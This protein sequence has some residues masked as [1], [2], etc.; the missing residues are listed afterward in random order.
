MVPVAIATL[1]VPGTFD[2]IATTSCRYVDGI[3]RCRTGARHRS[4][5][6]CPLGSARAP[7][8]LAT[9]TVPGTGRDIAGATTPPSAGTS[10]VPEVAW[11]LERR[12]GSSTRH[13][14]CDS[15]MSSRARHVDDIDLRCGPSSAAAMSS[16]VPGTFM[17]SVPR[18][19]RAT[20]D[21]PLSR[22]LSAACP[23]RPHA[24]ATA[25]PEGF[26]LSS[27][28]NIAASA[29]GVG[30]LRRDVLLRGRGAS[31]PRRAPRSAGTCTSGGGRR[32]G[33]RCG[34]PAASTC[35]PAASRTG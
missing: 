22:D 31:P 17:T 15:R 32:T 28:R 5:S 25:R 24:G 20:P 13:D 12:P 27:A 1:Q 14:G 6:R 16:L 4:T 8:R 30:W 34:A 3:A 2:D 19:H 23:A 7:S 29:G 11:H 9:S 10:N 21:T 26:P 18:R 33:R 35:L